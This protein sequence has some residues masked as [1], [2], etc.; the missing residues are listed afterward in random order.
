MGIRAL[1]SQIYAS[2]FIR[3]AVL[4]LLIVALFL[5]GIQLRRWIGESTRHVRYQHDIVNAFYWGSETMKEARRL[6]PDEASANSLTGFCR[7]YLALYDRVKHKA[8]N[9]EYG[10]D[11][12]PLRLLVMAIWARQVRNQFP[13]VDDG[14]PKLVNPLLKINLL[15]ELLSAVAIFLLVRLCLERQARATQSDPLHSLA[16]QHRASI[17]GLAAASAAWLEPS[18]ILDAHGWPQWDVWILPFYLF[19][20][21]AALKNRWFVC[22]CLLAT[23]AM[24]KGQLLFVAPFFV[25]WP[26]WQKRWNRALRML[27][28]FIAMAAL[29]AS[30]WLLHAPAA[31]VAL[32][33]V[34]GFASLLFLQRELP[35]RCAWISGTAGCVAFIIGAFTG[36][37]FA[38]LKV[39]FLYGSEHYPYLVISSCYNLPSLL[40]KL[41]WSLKD[42]FWSVHFGSLDFHLTLQWTLRL[43]YLGALAVCAYG[44]ARQVRDRDPRVLIAITAPWLLMFALLGQMHERYLVWGAV[45]SAVTLGVSL[46]LSIIH[47]IISAASTAMIV[48]VM[49]ID[50][51]LEATLWAIDL[52]KHV[53]GYASVLVLACVAVYLW[54]T[55]PLPVFQRRAVRSAGAP[56]LSLGPEPEEA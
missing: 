3:R 38:W 56:S 40:S 2:K 4:A 10:L 44:A 6:S 31:W 49:L 30:P 28:G 51:K 45:V 48:H 36:G 43:L 37:S 18:M 52:L 8:Y 42:P 14:H 23:G 17:G 32:L 46:R 55:L 39:G 16:L 24:F 47:F 25:L 21:F 26:M 34:T 7:G 11:Y 35:H 54:N 29:I 27:A 15:C 12:P 9:K 13:G 33:A 50:K 5:G 41:G 1:L 53:R 22:G 19:A 20:A